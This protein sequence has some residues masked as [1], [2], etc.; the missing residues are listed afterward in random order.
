MLDLPTDHERPKIPTQ[1][2]SSFAVRLPAELTRKVKELSQRE[3]VTLYMTLLAA[4]Q[5]LLHRYSGQ[6]DIAVGTPIAGRMRK[7]TENLI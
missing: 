2:G 6:A 5:T 4:Y 7:E 3:G 1:R